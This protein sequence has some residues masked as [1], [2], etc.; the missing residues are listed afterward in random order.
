MTKY[1][2]QRLMLIEIVKKHWLKLI[3][4][5]LLVTACKD[6]EVVS[7][8]SY[9]TVTGEF[10]VSEEI[11]FN[12]NSSNATEYIWDFGDGNISYEEHPQH[13]YTRSGDYQVKLQAF[14]GSIISV[15]DTTFSIKGRYLSEIW[16]QGVHSISALPE[17]FFLFFGESDNPDN[18]FILRLPDNLSTLPFGGL[19]PFGTNIHLNNS[20]WFLM[21]IRNNPPY[22]EFDAGDILIAGSSF[23]PAT[24][25]GNG[26]SINNNR[27]ISI[28]E[29]IDQ[30]GDPVP[31]YEFRLGYEIRDP[32]FTVED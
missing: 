32:G 27:Y 28:T 2:K 13:I 17:S 7:P 5:S 31:F 9:F 4:L 15:Y 30:H 20:E 10:D 18:F 16:F 22:N 3:F 12:N 14:D 19:S 26:T 21:L 23:N 6:N 8:K 25:K 11:R 24:L 29:M 1:L